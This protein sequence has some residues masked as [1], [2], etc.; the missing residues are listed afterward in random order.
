MVLTNIVALLSLCIITIRCSVLRRDRTVRVSLHIK[1]SY[2]MTSD[3]I[4]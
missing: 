4:V 2:Q 3:I 1:Y